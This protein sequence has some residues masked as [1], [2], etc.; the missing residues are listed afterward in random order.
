MNLAGGQNPWFEF[1]P[2]LSLPCPA[3]QIVC[4]S[5][6][7]FFQR[8]LSGWARGS[9]WALRFDISRE[10]DSRAVRIIEDG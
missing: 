4:E 7:M 3:S 6:S 1:I 5:G 10:L 8:T 9:Q 2:C